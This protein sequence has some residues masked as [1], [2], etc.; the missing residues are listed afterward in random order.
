VSELARDFIG[1]DTIA[2][3]ISVSELT[4]PILSNEYDTKCYPVGNQRVC[5][6]RPQFNYTWE[7]WYKATAVCKRKNGTLPFMPDEVTQHAFEDYINSLMHRF[8]D[9]I[10]MAGRE[11]R[12]KE[13]TWSN[14]VKFNEPS[15]FTLSKFRV[16]PIMIFTYLLTKGLIRHY[17]IIG[18][19]SFN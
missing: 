7:T 17:I 18:I 13:W 16:Q 3:R 8:S 14:G 11:E 10:W 19:S 12:K 4:F 2:W 5:F 1:L 6:F 15:Y 9:D